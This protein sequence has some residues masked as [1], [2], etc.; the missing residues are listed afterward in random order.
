MRRCPRGEWRDLRGEEVRRVAR[1][2][3][4][5]GLAWLGLAGWLWRAGE[6]EMHARARTGQSG[7]TQTP[8]RGMGE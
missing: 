6:C 3:G 8:E 1:P 4:W 5:L 7:H 2:A